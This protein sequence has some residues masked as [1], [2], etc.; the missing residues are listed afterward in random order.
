MISKY[1]SNLM[2]ISIYIHKDKEEIISNN[3]KDI[4]LMGYDIYIGIDIYI[5]FS[6]IYIE[7]GFLIL[8][9]NDNWGDYRRFGGLDDFYIL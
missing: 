7:S 9:D 5:D 1:Q 8:D 6:E 3:Y 2:I 4:I